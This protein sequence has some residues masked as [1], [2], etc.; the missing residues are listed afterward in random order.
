M[1]DNFTLG[2]ELSPGTGTEFNNRITG[3]LGQKR[4]RG[5]KTQNQQ[6]EDN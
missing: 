1:D 4:I 6:D 3:S 2:T 5:A